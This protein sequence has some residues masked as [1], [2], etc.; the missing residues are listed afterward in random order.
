MAVI[1][2]RPRTMQRMFDARPDTADFRDRMFE[3][4]LVDVPESAPLSHYTKIGV[5]ILDQGDDGACTAFGLATVAHYLLRT[6][7]PASAR[8]AGSDRIVSTRMLYD[9]A[10]R[11]DEWR[12]EGYS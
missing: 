4:T 12:G 7:G 10:R 2:K 6:R 11:Y 1:R 5:P 3:P 8:S 9:M